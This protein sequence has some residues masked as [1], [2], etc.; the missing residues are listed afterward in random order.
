M[1]ILNKKKDN[2]PKDSIY[3]G[4]GSILGN[5]FAIGVDGNR[6]EVIN[7]YREYIKTE[8]KAKNPLVLMV[9]KSIK[10]NSILVCYCKPS[11]CH[12][13]VIK[14]V[15]AEV[16]GHER[17]MSYAGIGARKTPLDVLERMS[18]LSLRL[19]ELE[20]TLRS[21]AAVGADAAF[22][23]NSSLKE[24]YLP[25]PGFNGNRSKLTGPSLTA[26]RLASYLHPTWKTLPLGIQKLMARNCHQVLGEKLDDPVDFLVCWT[27]DGVETFD[28]RTRNTGGTGL[29]I[30]LA[31]RFQV[32][33]FNLR[34]KDA[35]ERLGEYVRSHPEYESKFHMK[36]S[37]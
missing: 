24:I 32:P 27:P 21:G 28:K 36:L 13:D 15:W 30:E 5:P 22:E 2:I 23:L 4:R 35:V 3:I 19:N 11:P 16:Q 14:E 18:R 1:I 34:N 33:V 26:M 6:S 9:L 17:A 7:K 25:K 12:G 31:D 37:N 20:Y 29:A 8:I 10:E